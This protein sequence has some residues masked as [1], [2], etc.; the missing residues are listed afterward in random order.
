MSKSKKIICLKDFF[1]FEKMIYLNK[2]TFIWIKQ[3]IF[4]PNN[5]LFKSN[6]FL[7]QSKQ[8][9]SLT[10]YEYNNLFWR[11][12]WFKQIFICPKDIFFWIEQML[13]D[14]NKSF[15]RNKKSLSNELF[16]FIQSNIFSLCIAFTFQSKKRDF[17]NSHLPIKYIVN[18][19]N[20]C[21]QFKHFKWKTL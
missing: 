1:W 2:I 6:K 5:N 17:M 10:T 15:F 4:E 7:P 13:F 3:S 16:S 8:I 12:I 18:C 21:R 11:K 9:I 19:N 14:S 20:N